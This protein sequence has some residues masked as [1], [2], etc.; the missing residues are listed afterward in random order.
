MEDGELKR[1][2][3]LL[4]QALRQGKPDYF[5]L[6]DC[7]NQKSSPTQQLY[8]PKQISD[9]WYYAEDSLGNPVMI[10]FINQCIDCFDRNRIS[11]GIKLPAD[12]HNSCG[13]TIEIAI[14][15]DTTDTYF[16]VLDRY[17]CLALDITNVKK[18]LLQA[19][20]TEQEEYL[21]G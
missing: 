18:T 5:S 4:A 19:Q 16:V 2:R 14:D 17:S 20:A 7:D 10:H 1:R 12:N 13:K 9:N 21:N 15:H 3:K 8:I 11:E 6:K